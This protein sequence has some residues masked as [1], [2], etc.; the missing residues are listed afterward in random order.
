[1]YSSL[2]VSVGPDAP[3]VIA[4]VPA[5]VCRYKIQRARLYRRAAGVVVVG[6]QLEQAGAV[7]DQTGLPPPPA[8]EAVL[9][10][11]DAVD[12]QRLACPGRQREGL[13]ALQEQA[14]AVGTARGARVAPNGPFPLRRPR[15]RRRRDCP[16]RW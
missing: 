16:P 10:G 11:D 8:T 4:P 9:I 7:H 5:D 15:R 2:K 6:A 13:V 12:R 3:N 14:V 1:M